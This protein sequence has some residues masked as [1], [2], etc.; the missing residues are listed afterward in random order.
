MEEYLTRLSWEKMMELSP[1]VAFLA[2]LILLGVPGNTLIFFIY[3]RKK[4]RNHII[5]HTERQDQK[6]EEKESHVPIKNSKKDNP[7]VKSTIAST[8]QVKKIALSTQDSCRPTVSVRRPVEKTAKVST[9]SDVGKKIPSRTTLMM[10]VLTVTA[11]VNYVP[12]VVIFACQAMFIIERLPVVTSGWLLVFVALDRRQRICQPFRRHMSPRQALYLVLVSVAL[13]SA[14]TFPFVSLRSIVKVKTGKDHVYGT[15]CDITVEFS[16]PQLRIAETLTVMLTLIFGS[17]LMI[18]SYVNIGYQLHRKKSRNHIIPHTER[19]DQKTEEKE[20]HVPIKNSKKDNPTVKSTI[21][22][23]SQVKKTALSTQDSC[24]PTVSVR[25]HERKTTKVSTRGHVGKK[26]PSRTTLMMFVVTVTA[27]VTYVPYVIISMVVVSYIDSHCGSGSTSSHLS[28]FE[29][30]H[31]PSPSFEPGACVIGSGLRSHL[32]FRSSSQY[33]KGEDRQ[34]PCLWQK[35][36][37]W[38]GSAPTSPGN[39]CGRQTKQNNN[40]STGAVQENNVSTGKDTRQGS[41]KRITLHTERQ[42]QM[43]D[44]KNQHSE[45]FSTKLSENNE[46]FA[47]ISEN[48][49]EVSI[50]GNEDAITSSR[51][52]LVSRTSSASFRTLKIAATSESVETTVRSSIMDTALSSPTVETTIESPTLE[53]TAD[54]GSTTVVSVGNSGVNTSRP[55]EGRP[56]GKMIKPRTTLMMFVITVTAIV[57]FLPYIV[58]SNLSDGD[59]EYCLEMTR[60]RM[61]M[62]IT[63]FLFVN[64]NSIVN[65]FVYSFCNPTFRLKCYLFFTSARRR[66]ELW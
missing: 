6:T 21:A 48:E 28:S 40:N 45:I 64:I 22:S 51:Q 5:P 63:A 50:S 65:P 19:Q 10:F 55:P 14:I 43:R 32:P 62:C 12:H 38:P 61:N 30:T 9:C 24:R 46:E 37:Q 42:F 18:L 17:L 52:D 47:G 34:G 41:R 11:I 31:E 36:P 59:W 58:I 23:T 16:S 15:R 13:A 57:V 3:W 33:C 53:I 7:T 1:S 27:I 26:I 54:D 60:W 39:K 25:R 4:S 49:S 8:S 29:E 35:K 20:S 2:V 66:F 44:V 56:V